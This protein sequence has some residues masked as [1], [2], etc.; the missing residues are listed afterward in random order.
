MTNYFPTPLQEF[1]FYDKYSRFRDDLGRRETWPEAVERATDFLR[2]LSKNKLSQEVYDKIHSFILERKVMPSLRLMAMAGEAARRNNLAIFNC[3]YL[4][5]DSV[6]S[7]VEIMVLSMNGCGLG[8]SVEKQYISKL[9]RVPN[10]IENSLYTH[11]IPDT[12]EGWYEALRK[13][14]YSLYEGNLISFNFSL[15]RPA[16]SRLRVKGG[17]A[18]GPEVLRDCLNAITRIFLNARGRKLT[19]L[20]CSDI[21]CWIGNAAVAGGSRRTAML[22]LSDMDDDLM[23]NAKIGSFPRIRYNVNNSMVLDFGITK[24]MFYKEMDALFDGGTG[25]RGIFNRGAAVI[26][27]PSRRIWFSKPGVN[28]CQP[29]F[30][31]VLTPEGIKTLDKVDIK[32]LI[33]SGKQWTR[34]ANKVMTGIKPVNEYR[35]SFGVFIGTGDHKIIQDGERVRV[36]MA[37]GIDRCKNPITIPIKETPEN[38]GDVIHTTKGNEVAKLRQTTFLGYYPVY[39][40]TV[41][42]EE[43]TYWTGGLL[44]SNCAEIILQASPNGGGLCN[45]SSVICGHN[46]TRESLLEKMEVATIIGTIQ[47][48]A[49]HFPG[50]RDGWVDIQRKERLLGVDLNGQMDCPILVKDKGKLHQ[51]LYDKS[52][53]V[54][55]HY[56]ALL[57]IRQAAAITCVKPNGNSSQLL[58][59]ASGLHPRYAPFYIRRVQVSENSP[60]YWVLKESGV[61][62]V[63]YQDDKW[64]AEFPIKSPEKSKFR[65]DFSAIDMCEFWLLNKVWYTEHNPSITV[66]YKE[67]EREALKEWLWNHYDRLGGLS[68]F[69]Y[70]D[71]KYELQPYEEITEEQYE[72]LEKPTID[73]S[74]L[75]K[76][77]LYDQTTAS[78]EIGCSGGACAWGE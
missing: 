3:G 61:K 75:S 62:L 34:I 13:H 68:F 35:T 28:A 18:S 72:A 56:A 76:Y 16:G 29:G 15:I 63:H 77:E 6:D 58:N 41:E 5:L 55:S 2:E 40:I 42:A 65:K 51:D 30:A 25:E 48:T 38:M 4:T 24:E 50:L 46:D 32:D 26:N 74:L 53:Q 67:E 73:W 1:V 10:K 20:E 59:C 37:Y 31:T 45:L 69:P 19:S 78:Q 43:H 7:F 8:Y 66:Y 23:R 44:V 52:Y 39:D 17:Q 64:V 21:A 22:S 70:S 47:A 27:S 36:D 33:W 11:V 54:N 49:E 14:L 9:P 60:I 12:T 71:A 57:G